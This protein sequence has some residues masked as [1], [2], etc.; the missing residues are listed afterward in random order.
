MTPS[1]ELDSLHRELTR[2]QD[3]V[4]ALQKHRSRQRWLAAGVDLVLTSTIA[5]AAPSSPA[6][7][8]ASSTRTPDR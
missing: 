8:R 7:S 2:L 1:P 5:V 4:A 6:S 3:Q